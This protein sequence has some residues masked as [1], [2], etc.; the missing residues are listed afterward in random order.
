MARPVRPVLA[1]AAA[2]AAGA[3]QRTGSEASGPA[4]ADVALRV[5]GVARAPVHVE[6]GGSVVVAGNGHGDPAW[7]SAR[8]RGT[9]GR[10]VTAAL[11]R[12][13]HGE[14]RLVWP[15]GDKEPTLAFVEAA[16]E[17]ARRLSE[18]RGV[19]QIDLMTRNGTARA[20]PA[21]RPGVVLV[22]TAGEKTITP[23]MIE[24]L[25]ADSIQTGR[26]RGAQ[27]VTLL[28]QLGVDPKPIGAV[29]VHQD[30]GQPVRM[31]GEA[32]RTDGESIVLRYNK[33]GE[34][35]VFHERGSNTVT[36]ARGVTRIEL[37]PTR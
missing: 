31:P 29:V 25:E 3:C 9:D 17:K 26:R 13:P 14:L 23:E 35:R 15:E 6:R 4:E 11:A 1:L 8:G 30:G 33:R 19:T 36:D 16:G 5:D 10:F 21:P 18:A 2:L 7:M 20:K 37:S 24:A 28:E 34:L 22:S 12:Y 32:L 27:L